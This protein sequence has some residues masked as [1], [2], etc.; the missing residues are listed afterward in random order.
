MLF[1]WQSLF[2]SFDTPSIALNMQNI[3]CCITHPSL[4]R[5]ETYGGEYY[6]LEQGI[7]IGSPL[8][9]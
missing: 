8:S 5:V 2:M 3:T 6:D 9:R 4:N 7:S 1:P